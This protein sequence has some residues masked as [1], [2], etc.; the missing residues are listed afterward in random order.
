MLVCVCVCV[1]VCVSVCVSVCVC[2]CLCVCVCVCVC[3]PY[4]LLANRWSGVREG[5]HPIDMDARRSQFIAVRLPLE[6]K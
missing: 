4:T 6:Y 1:C 3:V 2:V 5:R